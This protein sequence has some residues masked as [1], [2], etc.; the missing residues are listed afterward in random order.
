MEQPPTEST[1]N[2]KPETNNHQPTIITHNRIL[3]EFGPVGYTIIQDILKKRHG[4][5]KKEKKKLVT[6]YTDGGCE[7]NPGV[8]GWAAVL[9]YGNTRKEI[10]GSDPDTTNNRMELTAALRALESL[11]ESCC[12]TLFT[13]SEYLK[14]GITEWLPG[15]KK[16]NW[17]RKGGELK[18]QDLWQQLDKVIERHE[19]DWQWVRGHYGVRENE[20]CDCL[21]SETIAS[22]YKKRMKNVV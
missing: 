2:R 5:M 16:K 14:R 20:R 22:L 13:D 9:L 12:V 7:P 15:W 17:K 10:T 21:V 8:G 6:I 19:V 18:N 11:K 3:T 4:E 1:R